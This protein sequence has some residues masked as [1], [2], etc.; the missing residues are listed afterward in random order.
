MHVVVSRDEINVQG[1]IVIVVPLTSPENK[2]TGVPK[3]L[4][5]FRNH[6]IRIPA[7]QKIWDGDAPHTQE[8]DSLA[9]TEQLFCLT[10]S[11]LGKRCG[12]LTVTARGSLEAGLCHVLDIPRVGRSG[13]T[14]GKAL[15]PPVVFKKK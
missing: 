5:S 8:G 11:H 2:E 14:P 3:N 4:G 12:K 13:G 10:Q 9:K 6:R 1:K 15:V 7:D